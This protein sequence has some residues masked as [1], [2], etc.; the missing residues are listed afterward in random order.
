MFDD[1]DDD[2]L[3][4]EEPINQPAEDDEDK[5]EEQRRK[6]AK[7]YTVGEVRLVS[8]LNNGSV[9]VEGYSCY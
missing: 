7:K 4:L 8:M 1:L 9:S 6:Q 3:E 5:A 2:Q